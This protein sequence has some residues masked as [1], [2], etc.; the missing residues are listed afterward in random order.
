MKTISTKI[1][2][3][4]FA[5]AAVISMLV[6]FDTFKGTTFTA[7]LPGFGQAAVLPPEDTDSDHDGLSDAQ[8]AY[9]NTDPQDPDTDRDGFK[10]GEEVLSGHDPTIPGPD[11]KINLGTSPQNLTQRLGGLVL[12]GL[13]EGSLKQGDP[14]FET[15]VNQLVDETII[16]YKV[17][18]GTIPV[19][20][21]SVL[22]DNDLNT[23][24][25][26]KTMKSVVKNLADDV[27]ASIQRLQKAAA[28]D[29]GDS[30]KE[31][32]AFFQAEDDRLAGHIQIL[33]GIPVPRAWLVNHQKLIQTLGSIRKNYTLIH[34]SDSSTDPIQGVIA[35]SQLTD[36][37]F[38]DFI[39][40][41]IDF[42][43]LVIQVP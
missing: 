34:Q 3:G 11:D 17:N 24:T 25:Y 4:L 20:A 37:I 42:R 31:Y 19:S 16:Q 14:K 38:K 30:T 21:L 43:P 12:A 2:I 13:T 10:D 40:I 23:A 29:H 6:F 32:D 35:F 8:E 18:K 28:G 5:A 1:L 27:F 41:V 39:Q 26:A 15:S 22:E 7:S 36:L 9:W 33:A